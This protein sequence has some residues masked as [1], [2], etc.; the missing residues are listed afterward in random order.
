[1]R[2]LIVAALFYPQN[3]PRAN[4]ASE[5][6]KEFARQGHEVKVLTVFEKH[7]YTMLANN[8]GISL[9]NLG[10]RRWK[11]P[12]FGNSRAGYFL[13]RAT[14]R[15]LSLTTEYPDIELALLVSKAL[16]K[17][18]EYDLLIS[19]A[20]P[21]PVHWGVAAARKKN[22]Q[23]SKVWVADCGDPYMG[24][25]TDSFR[26]LFYFKYIEKWFMRK[27]DFVS[28]PVDTA[29]AGYYPEFQKKIRIIPQGFKIEPITGAGQPVDNKVPTFAY[30]G[31]F[32]PNI[33]DPRP[34]LDYLLK[35]DK[36]FRFIV[37][38]KNEALIN[39]YKSQLNGK[40]E[41]KDYISRP[42][43]L[44]FMTQMDFL[45]N[46]DNNTGVQMPSKLIDYA[47][48][49]RPI[50]NIKN[51]PDTQMV[52]EFLQGDYS[53]RMEIINIE[54]YNIENVVRQFIDLAYPI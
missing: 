34:F 14:F 9:E 48:V 38:T 3:S 4:R 20:V 39:H 54:Q 12:D 36:E 41:V 33:R 25:E 43:L 53:R 26:K 51:E 27:A 23:I 50:L 11:S 2:I 10:V 28:I 52:D 18:N 24:C 1:M 21:Y 42:K 49:D 29:R 44:E 7:D 45:V 37:F 19:I 35:I 15:L 13:T 5:L 47:L 32:I 17:E 40:L 16:K 30:A 6:A 22:H 46:F 8:F 31:G